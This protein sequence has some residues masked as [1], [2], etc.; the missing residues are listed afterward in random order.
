MLVSILGSLLFWD[1]A[2]GICMYIYIY[3]Y[4]RLRARGLSPLWRGVVGLGDNT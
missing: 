4:M 1:T 3:I 2:S